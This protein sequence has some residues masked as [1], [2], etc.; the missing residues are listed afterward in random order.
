MRKVDLRMNEQYTYEIIKKL[1][2]TNANKKENKAL[3]LVFFCMFFLYL[4]LF[5][6]RLFNLT[7]EAYTY[8]K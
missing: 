3:C 6:V 8:L 1:V 2:D 5:Y 7:I 4:F